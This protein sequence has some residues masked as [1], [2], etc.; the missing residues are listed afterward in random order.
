MNIDFGKAVHKKEA[1]ELKGCRA[2]T[3][4]TISRDIDIVLSLAITSGPQGER[5]SHVWRPITSGPQ[6]ELSHVWRPITAQ[7]RLSTAQVRLFA[8]SRQ[9]QG[10][11]VPRRGGPLLKASHVMQMYEVVPKGRCCSLCRSF[12]TTNLVSRNVLHN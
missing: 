8:H 12:I 10:R 2:K 4:F 1:S 6:G 7:V 9:V 11:L 3:H 5:N